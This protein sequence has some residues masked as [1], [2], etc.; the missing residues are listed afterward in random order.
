MGAGEGGTVPPGISEEQTGD[1]K[2]CRSDDGTGT[3]EE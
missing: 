1:R 3:G 2:I